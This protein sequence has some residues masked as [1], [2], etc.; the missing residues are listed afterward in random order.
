MRTR[1][2]V[3]LLLSTA[4]AAC[5][6]SRGHKE[7]VWPYPEDP[8]I[9]RPSQPPPMEQPGI[10][11]PIPP[12]TPQPLPPPGKPLPSYPK[13]ADEV[14]GAAVLSLLQ[15]A[16]AARSHGNPEQAASALERAL[17]IEPRNYFVWS[18]LAQ[19]HLD[20]GDYA[21]AE[22]VAS[23]S[24]SLARGNV[25]VELENWRTIAAAR[26]GRGDSGGALQ[27]QARI[28]EIQRLLDGQGQ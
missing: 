15:Q 25:Y 2:L 14:S 8:V 21:Q 12:M 9:D 17:R 10:P 11:S 22:S 6:T 5:G 13:T 24:N 19:A 28:D 4:L 16:R 3:L 1:L 27:A 20:K 26:S 18:A 23:R 7:R